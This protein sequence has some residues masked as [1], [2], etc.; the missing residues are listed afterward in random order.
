LKPVI[1]LGRINL[2]F[3]VGLRIIS[4][5]FLSSPF[6]ESVHNKSPLLTAFQE[7]SPICFSWKESLP[8]VSSGEHS[9]HFELSSQTE[10]GT[11]FIHQ[12]K[13]K[14]LL[15]NGWWMAYSLSGACGDIEEML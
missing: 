11:A 4:G 15:F 6:I 12:E 1:E 2:T 13:F 14:R 3:L 9:S 5:P 10:D 8:F 7:N